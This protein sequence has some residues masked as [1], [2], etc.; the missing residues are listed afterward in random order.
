MER[1]FRYLRIR[2]LIVTQKGFLDLAP[3]DAEQHDLIYLI[4][5]CNIPIVLRPSSNFCLRVVGGCYLHDFME[6]KAAEF[7]RSGS[8]RTENIVID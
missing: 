6:G 8:L 4:P 2:R 7:L 1:M 3:T 5:G